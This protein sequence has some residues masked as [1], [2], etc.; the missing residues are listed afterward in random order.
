MFVKQHAIALI[1][2]GMFGAGA[3]AAE[4]WVNTATQAHPVLATLTAA[5]ATTEVAAGQ[6]VHVAVTLKVRNKAQLDALTS[7]LLAGTS[8]KTLSH[9]EFMAQ[10]APT[11]AQ[12]DKVV[13]HLQKSGFRN[14]K[15]AANRMLVSADGSA[16]TAKTAFNASLRHVSVNG[17]SGFA[18]S[19]AAQVP[20][21]LGNIVLSV[22]G[23][24]NVHQFH[25]TLQKA[26]VKTLAAAKTNSVTGHNPT[27][28]PLIYN[29]SSLPA[30]TNTTVGIISEGDL[31]QTLQDLQQFEDSAG[32]SYVQTNVINAG[33]ASSDTDGIGEWNLDSQDILAAAGGALQQMNFYVATSMTNADITAA[34]NSAVSD[35]SAKVINV[36]LGECESDAQSDGTVASD[37]QIFQTAVAQGQTFSVSTGDSGSAECGSSAGQSYP[38]TSP[39]VIAVGGTTLSTSGTKY[40]SESVWNGGG[41]GPSVVEAAPA[42]QT[43]AGVLTTSKTKRGVPDVS[44]DADPNSGALVIVQGSSQQIGGTSLAAP[45]FTGFWARIQSA[46]GNNLV[47][48][49]TAFYQYF[50]ANTGLYHDVTSG[51]NG[52]YKA[53]KGWDY[54]TGWGS[55]NVSALNTFIGSHSG[56]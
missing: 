34:Y 8:H 33:D 54:A 35:G 28:F 3:N 52:G 4:A 38:A 32:Y 37:D 47:S 49:N 22:H 55:L 39:Y 50:K 19:T 9:A 53:A 42:W 25:T 24:Q 46:N 18:N 2:A 1:I 7:S 29:A 30:A 14:I 5:K 27:D 41:G 44:F 15:V 56:F 45:L 26:G 40:S 6:S 11:Q 51:N 48:P 43:K 31:T 17:R 20:Q 12:V 23:L 16:A 10:Y 21:S 36:S 13:A